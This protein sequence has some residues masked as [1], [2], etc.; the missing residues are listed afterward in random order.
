MTRTRRK[1]AKQKSE[2]DQKEDSED[3]KVIEMA[4]GIGGMALTSADMKNQMQQIIQ[5]LTL[6]KFK[7]LGDSTGFSFLSLEQQEISS[8]ENNLVY[9]VTSVEFH[10]CTTTISESIE[11][12]IESS[13][14]SPQVH[15]ECP[16]I[17]KIMPNVVIKPFHQSPSRLSADDSRFACC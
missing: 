6:K 12:L 11:Y 4:E 7:L 16:I 15:L 3:E 14:K 1:P 13:Y 5:L 9:N 8:E 10:F 2:E 17:L